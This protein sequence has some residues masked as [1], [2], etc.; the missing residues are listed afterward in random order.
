MAQVHKQ[1]AVLHNTVE[2]TIYINAQDTSSDVENKF[3]RLYCEKVFTDF[4]H[5]VDVNPTI[6]RKLASFYE[7]TFSLIEFDWIE[8]HAHSAKIMKSSTNSG[9]V[10]V[11]VKGTR[12]SDGFDILHMEVAVLRNH[13]DCS[14]NLATKIR[15]YSIQS[16]NA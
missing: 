1:S 6:N 16:I 9:I 5:L 12:I 13:L 11:D 7:R 8:S 14:I 15:V 3:F 4:Y 2:D 10:R